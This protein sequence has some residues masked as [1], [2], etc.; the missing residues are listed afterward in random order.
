MDCRSLLVHIDQFG[1]E[2][3]PE[4]FG[5][6]LA[7]LHA[8]RVSLPEDFA[9]GTDQIGGR[10]TRAL[11]ILE[12]PISLI[13]QNGVPEIWGLNE[14]IGFVAR[15]EFASRDLNDNQSFFGELFLPPHQVG[16]ERVAVFSAVELQ[17]N[18]LS[19][20]LRQHVRLRLAQPVG[21]LARGGFKTE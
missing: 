20:Q 13:P 9:I 10:P 3:F 18:D 16:A 12:V 4:Y 14:R 7:G 11:V 19:F 17:P 1:D 2:K 15:G 21:F 8:R 5:V 6:C